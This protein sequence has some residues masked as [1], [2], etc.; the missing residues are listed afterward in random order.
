VVTKDL[1]LPPAEKALV[2]LEEVQEWFQ[3]V[4]CR[5]LYGLHVLFAKLL[6]L[7]TGQP[8]RPF[9]LIYP[10]SFKVLQKEIVKHTKGGRR[11][12]VSTSC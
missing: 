11:Q 7:Q 10:F 5:H 8:L 4:A 6:L 12:R 1:V 3:L 9:Y 2:Q